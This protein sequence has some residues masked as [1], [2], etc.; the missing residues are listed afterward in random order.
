MP[1][2]LILG[3]VSALGLLSIST[4]AQAGHCGGQN[5]GQNCNVPVQHI[6]GPAPHFDAMTT[7]S[8]NPMGHLRSVDFQRSP[9]VSIMRVHGM[10][11]TANLSDAPIGFT[12]GCHSQ[13]TQYCRQGAAAPVVSAPIMQQPVRAVGPRF[14]QGYDASKFAS[15][16]YGHNTFTPGIAHIPTSIVDR[17]PVRADMALNSGRAVP[18]PIANGG[19]APRPAMVSHSV[20]SQS[21]R[22]APVMAPRPVM[23]MGV[24]PGAPVLQSNGTYASTV[25]AG[26]TYWEKVSGPT[27][28][29][30]TMATQVICKRQLPSRVVRPVVGVPTPVPTPVPVQSG[31]APHSGHHGGHNGPAHANPYAG[32]T[33]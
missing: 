18:Q 21:Y 25:G 13:S 12:G 4:A 9:H 33:Y 15:R 23:S 20:M 6:P 28:L 5:F 1:I 30:N 3:A 17:D 27:M 10:M 22:T 32:W 24:R 2:K 8:V 7:T 16:Q 26:G 14:G 11:P 29:G 19:M 31:C